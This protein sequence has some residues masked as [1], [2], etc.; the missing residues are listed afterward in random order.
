RAR[1][2]EARGLRLLDF[3]TFEDRP[4]SANGQLSPSTLRRLSHQCSEM[5]KFEGVTIPPSGART[6]MPPVPRKPD[7][8]PATPAP[9][10]AGGSHR[11][12]P[13]CDVSD[14]RA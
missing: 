11:W 4:T 10:L 9:R 12:R 8:H 5:G 14:R 3:P 13:R 2:G 6:T 7:P 1:E